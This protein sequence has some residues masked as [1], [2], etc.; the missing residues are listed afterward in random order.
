M[1][2]YN[3]IKK[4]SPTDK[5]VI[6]DCKNKWNNL[7]KPL[8]GLGVLEE[9]ICKVSA[10]NNSLYVD[11]SKPSVIVMCADNGVVDQN[12][13]QVDSS[14]TK[15]VTENFT[16]GLTSVC[17]MSKQINAE[18]FAVDI[19][20]KSDILIDG[21]IKNKIM[22]G[23]N[24]ITKTSAMS[25]TDCEKAILVGINVVKNIK[26]KGFNIICTG[27]M[28]IG[29]TTTGSSITSCVL[30]IS[31]SITTGK[32]AGL[33]N[34]S[35]LHKIDMVKKAISINNPDKGDPID[36]LHKVGGLDIAGLV[37]VFLGCAYYKI[38]VVIDGVITL[39]A[40]ALAFML[41]E[42]TVDYMIPSHVSKEPSCKLLLEFLGLK[43]FIDCNMSIGEGTGAVS[44]VA[45]LQMSSNV[46]NGLPKFSD[47]KLHNYKE[48]K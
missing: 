25:K 34:E 17:L 12:V 14:V 21:V 31:P 3:I 41:N 39:S 29:N 22:Y 48:F 35:L 33:S 26:N 47:R 11:L 8:N 43:P 27:E 4:I 32:G 28:G 9:L 30:N 23:T 6:F 15:I 10:I 37:G 2:L 44:A 5:N 46:Y 16:K 24:D 40:A 18:V 1:E 19:G 36:I 20:V 7:L 13:T 38:P 45:L 42:H